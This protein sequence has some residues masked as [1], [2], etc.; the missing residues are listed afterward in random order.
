[1]LSFLIFQIACDFAE[2]DSLIY[3]KCYDPGG[4]KLYSHDFV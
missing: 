1:M 4:L 2:V 3:L